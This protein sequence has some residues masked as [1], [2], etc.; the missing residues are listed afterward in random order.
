MWCLSKSAI[1]SLCS[2]KHEAWWGQT[3]LRD[4]F[5]GSL[6]PIDARV[7]FTSRKNSDH[8]RVFIGPPPEIERLHFATN[9]RTV[10]FSLMASRIPSLHSPRTVK[11]G[12]G[13]P[14]QT[15][16]CI[17]NHVQ[18][19]MCPV[20]E[21]IVDSRHPPHWMG[22][23]IERITFLVGPNVPINAFRHVTCWNEQTSI[24]KS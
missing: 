16:D 5:S 6:L 9:H 18:Q 8:R 17:G 7:S 3:I 19:W 23:V 24:R 13:C 22:P 15:F 14:R 1:I 2:W 10:T 20:I 21:R 11:L 12:Y 4:E